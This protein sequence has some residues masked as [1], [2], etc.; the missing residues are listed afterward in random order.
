M[1]QGMVGHGK[2]SHRRSNSSEGNNGD[3]DDQE[4]D[5]D[6]LWDEESSV[7]VDH[8]LKQNILY[9]QVRTCSIFFKSSSVVC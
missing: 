9:I 3:G 6:S 2:G 7:K 1:Y 8:S 5:D 4:E